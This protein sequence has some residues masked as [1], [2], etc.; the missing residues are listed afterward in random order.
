MMNKLN[1]QSRKNIEDNFNTIAELFPTVIVNDKIDFEL[2]KQELSEVILDKNK[3]KYQFTWP[4]KKQAIINAN[5]SINKT[6]RP[7]IK[8]SVDFDNTN[9]VYIEG[10]NLEVLKILQES[11]LG[12]IKVIYIDPPYNTGSDFI[13][14]DNFKKDTNSE[15]IEDGTIDDYGKRLV[16]NNESNGRFHSD[17]LSMMYSRLKLARNLLSDDGVIFI[18][19]GD[20]EEAN[21]QK[22]CEEIFSGN[23][24]EHFIWKKK[25][26]AGNTEKIIGCLTENILCY[27]KEKKAGDFNYKT[28][29]RNYKYEDEHGK[30]NIEGIEKTNLG[31]YARPTMLFDI[32]DPR[33]GIHFK[34][35]TDMRWTLGLEKINKKIEEDK[36]YFDY[37]K[38]KVYIKK[39][40]SDY[41]VTQNVYYNLLENFGS[42]ATA[43]EEIKELF[44]N[45][46][47]FDTPKPTE[48][49]KHILTIATEKDSIILDFFSGSASMADATIKL[50][51]K[52]NGKRKF[53]MVQI[54]E[55]CPITS[56]AYKEGYETICDIG[57][58]RIR[59][60][61]NKIKEETKADI[62]Y[63]FR[64]Y[65]VDSSNMKDVYYEPSELKQTQLNGF[66]TNIKEDR[67][68]E[69]LLTQVI[70]NLG[71]TLDLKI[72][73][74]E[75]LNNKVFYVAKNSLVACFDKTIDINIIDEI[76]KVKPLKIVFR[77]NSFENDTD[78][79]N[80][81]ERI[82]KLS[83]ET[84]VNII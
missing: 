62:D 30:Y 41:E 59:R 28:Y 78:K 24:Y 40:E 36:V 32:I 42:L 6:L 68:S 14:N 60:V 50:N 10:D 46:E 21:L 34:P 52:D 84:E 51:A 79:I 66:E 35:S 76:C 47:L 31:T 72:E 8:K 19:I 56:E 81:Y 70:L 73:E 23:N 63:G 9:N 37:D 82:K 26:G 77:E 57:E 38:R 27:F 3:E 58:E 67:T 75:I 13:Y 55:K 4:G 17:W 43:K 2:L 65:K 25:G 53:I 80:S 33:T 7:D 20:K 22:I 15:L 39:Y 18:S 69:D 48:L 71:L 1:M 16:T 45:R 64:V 11:Y 61:A 83:P 54:P 12:K 74:K 5:K 44:G 49:L 29:E